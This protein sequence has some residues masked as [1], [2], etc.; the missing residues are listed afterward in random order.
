MNGFFL[1]LVTHSWR[2]DKS[3]KPNVQHSHMLVEI[4]LLCESIKSLH[5]DNARYFHVELKITSNL[6]Y[7]GRVTS[8]ASFD[9]TF[10]WGIVMID[11]PSLNLGNSVKTHLRQIKALT[12]T[13]LITWS[14]Q[15]CHCKHVRWYLNIFR[16][17]LVCN[18]K[19]G[20]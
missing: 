11:S 4:I 12:S 5:L 6:R 18:F 2:N 3:N 16:I 13:G 14:T 9:T 20:K 17:C 1:H 19:K 10:C 7:I 15:V 8:F